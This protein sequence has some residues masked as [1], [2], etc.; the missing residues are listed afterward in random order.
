MEL[1]VPTRRTVQ[2]GLEGHLGREWGTKK[3]KE[4]TARQ[5]VL[6]KLTNF[7]FPHTGYILIGAGRV[8]MGGEL[9]CLWVMHLFPGTGH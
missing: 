5:E 7:Y 2:Q 9:L 8:C 3:H 1:I 4:Q 6:F